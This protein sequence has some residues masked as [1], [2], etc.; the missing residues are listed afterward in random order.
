[1]DVFRIQGGARLVGEVHVTGAKNSSLK[2]MAAALLAPGKTIIHAVPNIL[3]VTI[4][5]ELLRRLGC[6]VSYSAETETVEIELTM[7]WLD[8]CEHQLQCLDH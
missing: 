6:S 1:V 2:L 4:M 8:E 5:A 3:D 7:T